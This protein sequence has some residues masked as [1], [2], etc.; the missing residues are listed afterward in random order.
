MEALTEE[1]SPDSLGDQE[2]TAALSSLCCG[3]ETHLE[4][5]FEVFRDRLVGSEDDPRIER[6]LDLAALL[7]DATLLWY[8]VG[9]GE[10]GARTICK[11]KYLIRIIENESFG[12]RALRSL[13]WR[14]PAEWIPLFHIGAD[15]NFHLDIEA[16]SVLRMTSLQTNYLWLTEEV[17]GSDAAGEETETKAEGEHEPTEAADGTAD[18]EELESGDEVDRVPDG[19][20]PAEATIDNASE[21]D[22]KAERVGVR[23]EEFV[24]NEGSIAHVYVSGRRP[25]GGAVKVSLQPTPLG[26]DFNVTFHRPLAW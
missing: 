13:S 20:P 24:D 9:A 7:V 2:F 5:I 19:K 6:L 8:P 18:A 23:P 1:V 22:A 14:F 21:V 10:A 16:P 11:L 3:P 15:A 4:D 17:I 12:R 25:V 26:A